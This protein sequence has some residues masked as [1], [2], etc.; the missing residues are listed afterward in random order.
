VNESGVQPK[1]AEIAGRSLSA[2]A[3]VQDYL[4][5]QFDGPCLTALT[6]PVFRMGAGVV[7]PGNVGYRDALCSAIGV[8]VASVRVTDEEVQIEFVNSSSI[9]VS[10]R[11]EDYVGPE[12]I[13]YV[14]LDGSM[15]VV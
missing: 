8:E 10:L 5:F 12:A 14:A 9:C 6:P 11:A 7:L 1:I 3:F 15:T 13:N 2:V 4:Q